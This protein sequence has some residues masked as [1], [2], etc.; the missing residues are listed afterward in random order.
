MRMYLS[1]GILGG[2]E[3]LVSVAGV[4]VAVAAA[5]AVVVSGCWTDGQTGAHLGLTVVPSGGCSCE[6]SCIRYAAVG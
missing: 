2:P 6:G 5:V 3:S 4:A 1:V